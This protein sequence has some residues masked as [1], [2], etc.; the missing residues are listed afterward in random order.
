MKTII[1]KTDTLESKWYLVNAED[2]VLGR[3]ASQVAFIV[4]GKHKPVYTPHLDT[5]DHVVVINAEKIRVTGRKLQRKQ[6]TRYT[7]Y[8]GGLRIRLIGKELHERPET[9]L[10]HA[11]KGMLPKNRLGSRLFKKVKIYVGSDHPHQAQ[12]PEDLPSNLRKA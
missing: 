6:Y 10:G 3:L 5:G 12:H 4:K 11:I 7:G 9:V 1:P 8:P 2:Q